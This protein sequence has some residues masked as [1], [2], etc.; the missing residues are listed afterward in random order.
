MFLVIFLLSSG[1]GILI[2][3]GEFVVR[4][5]ASI[6][7]RLGIRPIVIGL[8]IVA[9]GTSAPELVVNIFSALRGTADIAIGNVI[10]SNISNIFL[11]LG[12]CALIRPL[13]VSVGT[14]WKEIPLALLAVILVFVLGNDALLDSR[15]FDFNILSRT[16]GFALMAFFLIFIYYTFGISKVDEDNDDETKEYSWL[17]S[18]LLTIIGFVGLV[19]GGKLL[20]DNAIIL[21]RIAGMSEALIG[22][23]IV[24]IGTS[25]PELVTSI[26][27]VRHGH[28]DIAIGNI[29]GSNIFNIFWILG[30]TATL[31]PLPFN[32][33]VNF[34]IGVNIFATFILFIFMFIYS[35]HKLDRWQGL[36]MILFYIVYISY[37]VFRG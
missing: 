17:I 37:L 20:V 23:T 34:D 5:S 32:S 4:G 3:G 18:I 12:V 31:L 11:I 6:A 21:A 28:D 9:F 1:L 8:T 13:K 30:L 7:K 16:D 25:L 24:A 15:I 26:I 22:L 36:V 29:V 35:R 10:G 27:A 14:I 33:T 19:L 2:V